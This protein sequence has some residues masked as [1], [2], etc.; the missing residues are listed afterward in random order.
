MQFIDFTKVS[1][2]NDIQAEITRLVTEE[3]IPSEALGTVD[4]KVILDFFQSSLGQ[5]LRTAEHVQR[6][7][8][9]SILADGRELGFAD[10]DETILLQGVVDA[11]WEIDGKITVLD[12][13]TDYVPKGKLQEKATLYKGQMETYAY[14]LE[15]ILGKPVSTVLLYF[16]SAGKSVE[17]KF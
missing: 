5:T 1:N 15:K 17:W 3:K 10:A 11:F 8:K 9:F 14:A 4:A 7:F 2:K 16:F 6:E 12:F 13:K